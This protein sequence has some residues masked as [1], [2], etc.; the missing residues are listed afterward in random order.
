MVEGGDARED[1]PRPPP[2]EADRHGNVDS[3]AAIFKINRELVLQAVPMTCLWQVE[4]ETVLAYAQATRLGWE[5]ALPETVCD[6]RREINYTIFQLRSIPLEKR[7][8]K[9]DSDRSGVPVDKGSVTLWS[10]S[11]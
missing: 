1:P 11:M 4:T 2:G 7:H 6:R 9:R 8:P 5:T 10:V 3:N